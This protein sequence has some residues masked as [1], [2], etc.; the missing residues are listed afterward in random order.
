MCYPWRS[1]FNL[2]ACLWTDTE[3]ATSLGATWLKARLDIEVKGTLQNSH[4]IDGPI[5]SICACYD[6]L[7]LRLLLKS[8]EFERLRISRRARLPRKLMEYYTRVEN[9]GY[10]TDPV[11]LENA[12][13]QTYKFE[14]EVD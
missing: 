9:R 3:Q 2:N 11:K 14:N 10:K 7:G 13:L 6:K 4:T 5:F 12:R 1:Y 8:E